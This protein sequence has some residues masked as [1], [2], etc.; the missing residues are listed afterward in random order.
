MEV[1][2]SLSVSSWL[3]LLII[4]LLTICLLKS[5]LPKRS[6]DIRG[7]YVLITGCDSGFGR[8]TAIRLDEMGVRVLATCLTSDGEKGLKSV[9][10]DRLKT[11]QMDVTNSQQIKE[12]FEE[13]KKEVACAGIWGLVNNAGI[14]YLSPIEW[15]P[16]DVFIRSADVNLWGMIDVTKAFLPLI[17]KSKGRVVNLS[18]AAGLIS[19]GFYGSYSVTKY[20]VEA[21]SDALRR[22][23][24]PWGINVSMLEPGSHTTN[25]CAPD[26]FEQQLK[27]G[28]NQLSDVVKDEYGEEYLR[29]GEFDDKLASY[30]EDSSLD[31]M[32]MAG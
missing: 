9:T 14:L 18:S 29:T 8:A 27:K 3:L 19:P 22:E 17:K 1:T 20:G 4:G 12:V 16:L 28:W 5:L 31:S 7:K 30:A 2:S 11:F 15:T 21:F 24:Y 10:S 25:I 26:M 23:M 32:L 13:V 6:I